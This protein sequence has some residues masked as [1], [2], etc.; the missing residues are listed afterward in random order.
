MKKIN[1]IIISDNIIGLLIRIILIFNRRN[2]NIN[3]II[4]IN[5]KLYT[6]YVYIIKIEIKNYKIYNFN[7]IIKQIKRIIGIKKIYFYNLK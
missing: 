7:K 3:N 6:N 2:I 1:I 4:L 5:K